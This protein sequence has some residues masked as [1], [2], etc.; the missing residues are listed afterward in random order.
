MIANFL[1]GSGS[2][3]ETTFT[4]KNNKGDKSVPSGQCSKPAIVSVIGDSDEMGKKNA[5]AIK[6][7][8][9]CCERKQTCK[10]DVSSDFIDE[11]KSSTSAS[12][13]SE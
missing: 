4:W 11:V 10:E 3:T 8:I 5:E 6:K 1:S 13:L 12:T 7:T 2:V 9:P